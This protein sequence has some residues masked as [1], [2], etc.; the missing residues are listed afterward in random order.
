M[1]EFN[2]NTK[3]ENSAEEYTWATYM[4]DRSTGPKFKAHRNLGLLKNSINYIPSRSFIIYKKD[5][6]GQWVEKF[7]FEGVDWQEHYKKYGKYYPSGKWHV[8]VKDDTFNA[9]LK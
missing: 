8:E 9:T 6:D 7:R 4:P 3:K 1:L 5:E 2:P